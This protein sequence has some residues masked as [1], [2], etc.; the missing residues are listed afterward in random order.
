[1]DLKEKSGFIL[2][3]GID[4]SET[5]HLYS[6]RILPG[7]LMVHNAVIHWILL[8]TTR[9]TQSCKFEGGMKWSKG[10]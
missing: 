6:Q 3:W 1:M 10:R 5:F 9:E 8:W 4:Y 2:K 7:D